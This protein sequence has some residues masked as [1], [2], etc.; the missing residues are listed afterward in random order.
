M[1]APLLGLASILAREYANSQPTVEQ[2]D[3]ILKV[4]SPH[5]YYGNQLVQYLANTF[6]PALGSD[7]K[8]AQVLADQYAVQPYYEDRP[9]NQL[10]EEEYNRRMAEF[11]AQVNKPG[12]LERFEDTLRDMNYGTQIPGQGKFVGALP[13]DSAIFQNRVE[14]LAYDLNT[15]PTSGVPEGLDLEHLRNTIYGTNPLVGPPEEY[16]NQSAND[17]YDFTSSISDYRTG[18]SEPTDADMSQDRNNSG[19][20]ALTPAFLQLNMAPPPGVD[21]NRDFIEQFN[22]SISG[23][24]F[25][26][27]GGGKGEFD[28]DDIEQ[29][30]RGGIVGRNRYI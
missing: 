25:M 6:A 2:R 26:P 16:S 10:S 1:A 18:V 23:G 7:L 4:F 19:L 9:E 28:I 11:S 3:N 29:Y 24:D 30:L 27:Q 14:N 15:E 21:T 5:T 12:N 8:G 22:G 17:E 20:P 13:E